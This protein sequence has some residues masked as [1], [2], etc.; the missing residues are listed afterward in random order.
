MASPIIK[1]LLVASAILGLAIVFGMFAGKIS[2]GITDTAI[3]FSNLFKNI[4]FLMLSALAGIGIYIFAKR[5]QQTRAGLDRN[6]F[7]FLLIAVGTLI[8]LVKAPIV[9]IQ[10]SMLEAGVAE[11]LFPTVTGKI[12]E[13]T[14]SIANIDLTFMALATAVTFG[15]FGAM[16]YLG[17]KSH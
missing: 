15:I 3:A 13:G 4:T 16:F 2:A 1:G 11:S 17:L 12:T 14:L 7:P 9:N 8:F 6:N 5:S 10:K